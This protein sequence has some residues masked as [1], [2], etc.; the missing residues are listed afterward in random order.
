MKLTQLIWPGAIALAL[1]LLPGIVLA[2][3]NILVQ[4]ESVNGSG[5]SGTA[6]LSIAGEGTNVILDVEGLAPDSIAQGAMHAGTCAMPSASFAALP[7]LQADPTGKA[8]ATGTILFRG[9][10][11]V[12]LATMTDGEHIIVIQAE[13]VVACGVIPQ[14]ATPPTSLPE[15]GGVTSSLISITIGIFGFYLMCIGLYL[16]SRRRFLYNVCLISK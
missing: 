5:V 10:E 12:A 9:T 2:Q 1:L 8:T 6:T 4:L 13:D 15:T 3:E 16:R 14:L 11:D 7:E